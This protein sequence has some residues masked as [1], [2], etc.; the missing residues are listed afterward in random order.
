MTLF[1]YRQYFAELMEAVQAY[2]GQLNG[3][4]S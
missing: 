3:G 2:Y 4:K 1:H